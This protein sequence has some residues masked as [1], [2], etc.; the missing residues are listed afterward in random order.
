MNPTV[1]DPIGYWQWRYRAGGISGAGSRGELAQFK[2]EVV[3]QLIATNDVRTV[4]DLGC[5]DGVQSAMLQAPA[6]RSIDYL[7]VDVSPEALALCV[8]RN[9]NIT[10][11]K[12][13]QWDDFVAARF[14]GNADLTLS[15]DVIYHLTDDALFISYIDHLF[16]RSTRLVLVYS[17]DVNARTNDIHVRH[18]QFSET[19][20]R[21]HPEWRRV[22]IIPNRF[23]HDP[24]RPMTTS[25]A[26]FHIFAYADALVTIDLCSR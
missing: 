20:G 25:F 14:T 21:R 23:P 24:M 8:T 3:N 12:F 11:K 16:T 5:G 26:D 4:I 9:R 6:G 10:N 18:R 22:A 2:A 13:M 17:S 19:V 15:M 7:G 1:F